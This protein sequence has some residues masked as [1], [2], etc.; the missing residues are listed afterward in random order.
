M[1]CDSFEKNESQIR[2]NLTHLAIAIQDT[3]HT[4]CS[5]V[6]Y[7]IPYEISWKC[8]DLAVSESLNERKT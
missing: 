7:N 6:G 3:I 8:I 1:T 4:H 5:K 2:Q